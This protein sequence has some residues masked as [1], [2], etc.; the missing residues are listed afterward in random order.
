MRRPPENRQMNKTE[1][2]D[3]SEGAYRRKTFVW[4]RFEGMFS[5]R[6]H[7]LGQLRRESRLLTGCSGTHQAAD[8]RCALLEGRS[9]QLSD[10]IGLLRF[11]KACRRTTG[12]I[13]GVLIMRIVFDPG[14]R[15][16]AEDKSC[17]VVD[18]RR[19]PPPARGQSF[20][21]WHRGTSVAD[22]TPS[23][24]QRPLTESMQ[25]SR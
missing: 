24:C 6:Q 9:P 16:H 4:F 12:L 19:I 13:G 2:N 15:K 21:R 18:R 23:A 10:P 7:V 25:E 1:A 8:R 22:S 3:P 17:H 20:K 14:A 5:R 11:R